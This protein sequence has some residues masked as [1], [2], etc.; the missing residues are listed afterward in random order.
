[1]LMWKKSK[2]KLKPSYVKGISREESY[3]PQLV[4]QSKG[5]TRTQHS[6]CLQ[7]DT[8]TKKENEGAVQEEEDIKTEV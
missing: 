4:N 1:M 3:S 6:D 5:D 8:E 7:S 2:K